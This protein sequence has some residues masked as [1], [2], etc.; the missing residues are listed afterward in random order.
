MLTMKETGKRKEN[1]VY[2]KQEWSWKHWKMESNLSEVILMI[3]I[4]MGKERFQNRILKLKTKKKRKNPIQYSQINHQK[5]LIWMK[6]WTNSI[7]LVVLEDQQFNPQ[8]NHIHINQITISNSISLISILLSIFNQPS[9]TFLYISPNLLTSLNSKDKYSKI[10]F[11][12][13]DLNITLTK[14]KYKN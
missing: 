4:I 9:K 1:I 3:P 2:L 11:K 14:Q 13:E 6:W 5:F 10:K 8:H 7:N 12:S